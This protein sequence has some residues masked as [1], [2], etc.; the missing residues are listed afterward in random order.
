MLTLLL[1]LLAMA[2]LWV[3]LYY[4][5]HWGAWS[6][7]LS[8][9]V[10]VGIYVGAMVLIRRRVSALMEAIQG[11]ITERNNALMRK[12]Q[13]LG[14]RGG[15]AR[16]LMDMAR[17]DQAVILSEALEATRQMEPYCRW[18]LLLDRQINALRV[19]FLYPLRKFDEVDRLLPRSLLID[20]VLSCMLMCRQYQHGEDVALQKTYDTYRKKFKVN[21][22]LIY[23]TYA[24]MLLK[25]KQVEQA[26][27]VLLEGKKAT[28]DE[29]LEKNWEHVTNGRLAQ[30]SNAELG[31]PWYALLLEEPKQLKPKMVR[32]FR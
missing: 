19:Q 5:A 11:R 25:K 12:Y 2:G 21:A 28:E 23:A 9:F 18:S 14:G 10:G 29:I 4:G 27:L 17:K 15:D 8:G 22:T 13:H 32:R 26:R 6:G 20:P 31:E 16:R 7:V 24:W 1:S 30:F 3:G